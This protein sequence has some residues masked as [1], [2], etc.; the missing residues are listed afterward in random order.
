MA[1]T[2]LELDLRD[3]P[4]RPWFDS[5]PSEMVDALGLILAIAERPAWHAS[6]AC[7]GKGPEIFYAERGDDTRPAKDM[8]AACPVQVQCAEAG[9]RERHGVWGGFS[10]RQRR[11][12][13]RS[14]A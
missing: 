13:R 14:A 5:D 11:S 7:R 8:C 12:I 6:A 4:D 1:L 3:D 9:S 10:E 2:W